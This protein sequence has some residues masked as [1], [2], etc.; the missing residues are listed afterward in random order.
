MLYLHHSN[1]LKQLAHILQQQL[2]CANGKVLDTEQIL[3]QNPG[4]KRWLQQQLCDATGIA[5]NLNFPLPSR[6][7]WDIYQSQFDVEHEPSAYSAEVLRWS[8]M[9]LLRQHQDEQ[10]LKIINN[11][12]LQDDSGLARFQLARKVAVLFDQ[13]QVYR[14]DMILSWERNG[15]VQSSTEAW[16]SYLW[17]ILRQQHSRA[18]RTELALKLAE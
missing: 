18:H 16:Q 3:V 5:A 4:M 2:A 15:P 9:S 10:Q 12:C 13:Y 1:S 7:I 8:L 11:Y 14:P 6:F 17:Q